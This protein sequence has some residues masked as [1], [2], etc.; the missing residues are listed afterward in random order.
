MHKST[1]LGGIVIVVIVVGMVIGM[2]KGQTKK[3]VDKPVTFGA[4]I[5]LASQMSVLG[6]YMRNGMELAREDV[7]KTGILPE[8]N[9]TYEDACD[10]K[11]SVNA[12]QKLITMDKVSVI[13]NSFCIFGSTP[14]VPMLKQSNVLLF[15]TAAHPDSFLGES[16]VFSTNITIAADATE[17]AVYSIEKVHAKKAAMIY[18]DTPFGESYRVN[19]AKELEKQGVKL[20][21]A[22]AV[23]P[24]QKDFRTQI[25]RIKSYN[26]D[27]I[28]VIHFGSSLGNALKQIREQGIVVPVMGD[29]ESEDP[30][31]LEF[32]GNAA[33]GLI[34]SSSQPLVATS[35]VK[36]FEK[37]YYERY[38]IMPDVLATNAYDAVMLQAKVYA[39]CSGD[40][41]CMIQEL[42]LVKEYDGVS[43]KITINKDHSVQKHTVFKKVVNGKFEVIR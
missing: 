6:E 40:V 30:A 20:V 4:L 29:Y 28:V 21:I 11:S 34:I 39:T 16:H 14:V 42:E 26:P 36:D 22:E 5:P 31:V 1:I 32:A 38:G 23:S 15:N 19:Y 33:E 41:N 37:R 18:L 7:V 8:F 9:I 17:M 24:D 25:S 3:P 12:A 35:A 43:G 2:Y 27:I 10:A 13:S